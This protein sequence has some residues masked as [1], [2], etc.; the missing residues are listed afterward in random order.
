MLSWLTAEVTVMSWIPQFTPTTVCVRVRVCVCVFVPTSEIF[1][2]WCESF[3]SSCYFYNTHTH[4]HTLLYWSALIVLCTVI[5]Q[6]FQSLIT[7]GSIVLVH[8]L[9]WLVQFLVEISSWGSSGQVMFNPS[10][11]KL[12][13]ACYQKKMEALLRSQLWSAD[14]SRGGSEA[15]PGQ[16]AVT[17]CSYKIFWHQTCTRVLVNLLFFNR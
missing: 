7:L 12:K 4:T 15:V 13:Y 3:W 1:N 11:W 14:Q 16:E 8:E 9:V 5:N 10:S 17:Q 2:A 6:C